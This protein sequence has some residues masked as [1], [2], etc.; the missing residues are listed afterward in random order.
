MVGEVIGVVGD[1]EFAVGIQALNAK[2]LGGYPASENDIEGGYSADDP[3]SY[4]NLPDELRKDQSYRADTARL[5]EFGSLLQAFCRDRGTDRVIA[6]W[7]HDKYLAP[8]YNDGG[9]IGSKIALFACRQGRRWR[10]LAPSSSPRVFRT[11]CSTAS[12]PRSATTP[13]APT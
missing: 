8:A 7:G 13:I 4:S 2:T 11:R 12:G 6:N 9:V 1:P 5:T 3:A 10:R